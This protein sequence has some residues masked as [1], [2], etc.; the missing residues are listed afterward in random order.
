MNHQMS[1][2]SENILYQCFIGYK[3]LVTQ[4]RDERLF[5]NIRNTP[6]I[7]QMPMFLMHRYEDFMI[8]TK[9]LLD[10]EKELANQKFQNDINVQKWLKWKLN[11][12]DFTAIPPYGESTVINLTERLQSTVR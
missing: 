12:S 11:H 3:K 10:Y 9:T 4:L 1:T 2:T 5:V 6:T 8:L 7:V